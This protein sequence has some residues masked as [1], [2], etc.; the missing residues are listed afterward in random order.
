ML[1]RLRVRGIALIVVS[2][3]APP[4]DKPERCPVKQRVSRKWRGEDL[5]RSFVVKRFRDSRHALLF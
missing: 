2:C 4:Q 3:S 5:A 1:C